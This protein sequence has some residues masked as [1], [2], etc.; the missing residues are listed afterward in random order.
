MGEMVERGV[1]VDGVIV[2]TNHSSHMEVGL[3][4]FMFL[5]LML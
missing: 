4:M 1:E 3:F 2:A 5:L